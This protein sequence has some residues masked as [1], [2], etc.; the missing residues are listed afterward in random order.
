YWVFLHFARPLLNF[1]KSTIKMEME[2]ALRSFL[3]GNTTATSV[4]VNDSVS[5]R[6]YK[7]PLPKKRPFIYAGNSDRD[8]GGWAVPMYSD[9]IAHCLGEKLRKISPY[10]SKYPEWW[11]VL[12]DRMGWGLDLQEIGEVC[13]SIPELGSFSKLV[14]IDHANA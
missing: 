11:L 12:V 8:R 3:K 10:V 14:V 2:T 1:R 9:N 7:S 4:Q 5:F 13:R 6:L